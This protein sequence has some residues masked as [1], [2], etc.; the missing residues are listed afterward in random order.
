MLDYG[1]DTSGFR[2]THR[3]S[4]AETGLTAVGVGTRK[5]LE[6]ARVFL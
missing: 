3:R 2:V 5:R 4:L 6:I 1:L